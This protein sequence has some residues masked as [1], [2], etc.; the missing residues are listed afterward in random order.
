MC[1]GREPWGS[2]SPWHSLLRSLQLKGLQH[3]GRGRTAG[4]QGPAQ[5]FQVRIRNGREGQRALHT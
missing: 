4:S 5:T 1:V 2:L 3:Q